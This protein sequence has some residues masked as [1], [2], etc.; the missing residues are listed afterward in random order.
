MTDLVT[1]FLRHLEVERG[2]SPH[3][4]RSYRHDL[5]DFEAFL[6]ATAPGSAVTAVDPRTVRAYVA[7]LH[8][9]TLAPASIGRRIAA[10]RSWLKFLVRR[11]VIRVNPARD[12]RTPRLPTTLPNFLPVDD[13]KTLVDARAV[14]GA[15]RARDVAILELLYASGL[16]VAELVGLDIDHVDRATRTVHVRGKGGKERVV[17]YGAAA[18]RALDGYLDARARPGARAGDRGAVFVNP[19][20]ARLSVRSVHTIV[21]RS[22]RAAGLVR[23]VTPHTLRHTFATHLLDG[24]ADLRMIQE[25][26]GH[27]RLSTTQRYTHVGADQLMRVY[28]QAHPRAN[29]RDAAR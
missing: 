27:S 2:A 26:L 1:A 23:R 9:R 6:A 10:L 16:R 18:A 8:R 29:R 3:T 5:Q 21:R 4:L 12:V 19:R 11:G 22:A 20:G 15:A 14:G 28:D 7:H 17:P 25:L 13:A 24:G